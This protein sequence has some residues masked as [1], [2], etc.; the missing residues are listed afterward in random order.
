MDISVNKKI[1]KISELQDRVLL[2]KLIQSVFLSLEQY[3]KEKYNR[4][5]ERV[6]DEISV[7]REKYN[8]FSTICNKEELDETSES[9]YPMIED[10]VLE[11]K[12]DVESIRKAL[13]NKEEIFLFKIFIKK[14]Y[15]EIKEFIKN[16]KIIKGVIETNYR[17]YQGYFR[18]VEN[19][20]YV[21]K[22]EELYSSFINNNIPWKSKNVPYIRKMLN[23]MLV[24]CDG[25]IGERESIERIEVDFGE[26]SSFIEYNMVPLWNVKEV[27]LKTN[28]FSL[29]CI[30]KV[31]YKHI[32]SLEKEGV[33]NGYLVKLTK[34]DNA[35][36]L[37]EKDIIDI[38]SP[39]S[40][41]NVWSVYKFCKV[42][43][44]ELKEYR[45]KIFGNDVNMN[46]A[47]K[48]IYNSGYS[49]K[50]K[51]DLHRLISSFDAA[52]NFQLVDIKIEE[53]T[54][55][56][57]ETYNVNEFVIDEIRKEDIRKA[58][59]L[60]FRSQ[61]KDNYLNRDI[62][63]FL[64]SEVQMIYPEYYCEGKII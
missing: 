26:Y 60:Y 20:E 13:S 49:I 11:I 53:Y 58:L 32:V 9:F 2:K 25:E 54:S 10:D 47:G 43:E 40:E 41:K 4:I 3:T 12:Y 38:I 7:E 62:L 6:F 35:T 63:S 14:D 37:F 45:Y 22:I 33:D 34:D 19:E 59:V 16:T 64:I 39:T 42:N 24:S 30:D 48:L 8:I 1:E 50:T 56:E 46:F 61:N 52:K 57:K 23:V 15:L 44:E 21:K 36:V 29:P 31:N 18:V 55:K 17:S 51:G 27:Q 28:G 5:E